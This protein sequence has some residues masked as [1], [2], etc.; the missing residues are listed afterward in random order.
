MIDWH[1]WLNVQETKIPAEKVILQVRSNDHLSP[2]TIIQYIS[3]K[4]GG[5]IQVKFESGPPQKDQRPEFKWVTTDS[6]ELDLDS[7][8]RIWAFEVYYNATDLCITFHKYFKENKRKGLNK[9]RYLKDVCNQ[10]Q[11]LPKNIRELENLT[12]LDVKEIVGFGGIRE[13]LT[14]RRTN[15]SAKEMSELRDVM[16]YD[17]RDMPDDFTQEDAKLV[18]KCILKLAA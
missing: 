5:N 11:A 14:D 13:T 2:C 8:M 9:F 3:E 18:I 4:P 10:I 1:N 6:F 7:H 15:F 16:K 17:M 12:K